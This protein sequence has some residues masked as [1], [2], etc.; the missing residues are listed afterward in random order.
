MLELRGHVTKRLV[1]LAIEGDGVQPGEEVRVGDASI[2]KITSIVH[3]ATASAAIALAIVKLGHAKPGEK[4]VV[5]GHAA[6]V[7]LLAG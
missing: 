2:G 1:Q 5:G 3:E 7:R 6:E 4:V